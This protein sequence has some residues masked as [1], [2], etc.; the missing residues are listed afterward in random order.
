MAKREEWVRVKSE[1]ELRIGLTVQL[2]PCVW[3][4][5]TENETIIAEVEVHPM[6]HSPRGWQPSKATR[7][8]DVVGSCQ[9]SMDA[10]PLTQYDEDISEGRLYRL[11][12]DQLTDLSET[13][14][15]ENVR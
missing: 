2:R 14:E 4:G 3:C 5:R 15:L 12:D 9:R 11:A 7:A 1:D 8:F 13:R 10:G 6:A